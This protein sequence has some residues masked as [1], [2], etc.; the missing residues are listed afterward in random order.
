MQVTFTNPGSSA[1]WVHPLQMSLAG[2][3]SVTTRRTPADLDR[4]QV[5]KAHVV[6]G[7]ITLAFALETGDTAQLGASSSPK[8]YS[9]STRPAANTVPTFTPIWNTS[10]NALNWSDGT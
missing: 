6:A 1:I 7:D 3:S 2:G 10:D 8:S 5:F 9:N 4:E